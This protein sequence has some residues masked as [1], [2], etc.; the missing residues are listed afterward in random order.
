M[1]CVAELDE[2]GQVLLVLIHLNSRNDIQMGEF[3]REIPK[4]IKE[5]THHHIH[6][7]KDFMGNVLILKFQTQYSLKSSIVK[8]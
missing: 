6:Y 5:S 7:L 3:E 1:N 2:T 4:K 8:I